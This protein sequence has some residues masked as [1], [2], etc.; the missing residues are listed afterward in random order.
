MISQSR[1]LYVVTP[2]DTVV[3]SPKALTG[4]LKIYGIIIFC[5]QNPY[6]S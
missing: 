3:K 6:L 1:S 4:Y 5:N 2:V